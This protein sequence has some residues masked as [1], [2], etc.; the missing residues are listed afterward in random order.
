MPG[1]AGG[2]PY[3][4]DLESLATKGLRE[5]AHLRIIFLQIFHNF[6]TTRVYIAPTIRAMT[7]HDAHCKVDFAGRQVYLDERPLVLTHK[8]FELLAMLTANAGEVVP[9]SSLLRS[10]WGYGPEIRT[11]T[12]DVHI[13]RLRKKLGAHGESYIETIFGI[14]YRFQPFREQ[15]PRLLRATA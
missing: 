13:R 12:L 4:G 14:G 5:A 1:A 6:I 10:V 3:G 7:Y 2:S 9:R 8:E 11:R 15:A